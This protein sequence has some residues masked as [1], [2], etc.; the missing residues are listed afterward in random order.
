MKLNDNFFLRE[1]INESRKS[2]ENGGDPFGSILVKNNKIVARSGDYCV[3]QSDPTRHAELSLISNYCQS[4][5]VFSLR[6]Y[7]LYSST[8][9]CI[10]CAGSIHWA[11]LSKVVFALSQSS[12]KTISD[13][14]Q[15]PT[16]NK[17]LSYGGKKIEVI[18]PLLEEEALE[19]F[20]TSNLEPKI[21][22]HKKLFGVKD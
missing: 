10:M 7:V 3:K 14:N 9:P 11:K 15:K 13:G 4:N 18:G 5:K 6:G 16:L 21:I 22:R 19:V 2:V 1:A 8:E 12:L 17:L 20:K